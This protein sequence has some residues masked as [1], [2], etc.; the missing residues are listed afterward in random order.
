MLLQTVFLKVLAFAICEKTASTISWEPKQF[1]FNFKGEVSWNPP[2]K[3]S[4]PKVFT[5]RHSAKVYLWL[6]HTYTIRQHWLWLFWAPG[7][8]HFQLS[9]KRAHAGMHW[10][11]LSLVMNMDIASFYSVRL[12][13]S[14]QKK[15]QALVIKE[16]SDHIPAIYTGIYLS[17]LPWFM[18][19]SPR[20]L[21]P[22]NSP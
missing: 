16:A 4:L 6:F 20:D 5:I 21:G 19:C 10:S 7:S 9:F 17:I 11:A 1:S 2:P 8:L 12:Q 18:C 15:K 14:S 3:R 13:F 22:G